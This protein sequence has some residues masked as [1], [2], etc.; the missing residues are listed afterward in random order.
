MHE[1]P[2]H[3]ANDR[4]PVRGYANGNQKFAHLTPEELSERVRRLGQG[5]SEFIVLHRI[6]Y[7]PHDTMQAARSDE[8]S[9]INVSYRIGDEPWMEADVPDTEAPALFLAWA[10]DEPGWADRHPWTPDKSWKPVEPPEPD[11]ETAA[12]AA[13]TAQR[14]IDEGYLK[15]DEL[16]KT[17]HEMAGP[18]RELSTMQAR[19]IAVP[20][21]RK[22][23]D[24]QAEW[25]VTDCEVL[26]AA[27]AELEAQGVAA[28]EHFSC[29]Q[30]CGTTEIRDYARDFRGFVF[31]HTQDTESAVHG[32]LHLSFGAQVN[33]PEVVASVGHQIVK[34]LN[35]NGLQ[36][37]WDGSAGSRIK[38]V[39]LDWRRRLQ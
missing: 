3:A 15:F 30:N 16:V 22:R 27:F 8:T 33:K 7:R 31:F 10:R 9:P 28:R 11:P 19:K 35:E 14:F 25:G 5:D 36:T 13:A 2:A 18:D 20:L 21:W 1:S 39:D 29:C 37:E 38:I 34:V 26:T 23:L 32:T 12:W 6:P 4:L 17:L 24:E